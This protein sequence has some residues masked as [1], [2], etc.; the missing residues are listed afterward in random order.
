MPEK[1]NNFNSEIPF[2][3]LHTNPFLKYPDAVTL[4]LSCL[5]VLSLLISNDS[6]MILPFRTVGLFYVY[7]SFTTHLPCINN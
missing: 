6:A 7:M 2:S 3:K 5:L 4:E 1:I